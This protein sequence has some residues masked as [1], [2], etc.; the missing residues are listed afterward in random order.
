MR[1]V[2]TLAIAGVFAL[3]SGISIAKAKET[4]LP[5]IVVTATRTKTS[6]ESAPGIVEV[7]SSKEINATQPF[8]LDEALKDLPGVLTKR[9]K[10]LMDTLASIMLR[11]IPD[12]KRTLIM[13]DG[14]ILNNPYYGGV[15]LGGIFPENIKRIEVVEGPVSSLYGGY[16]MGGV[17][18]VIT[19]MPK[20]LEIKAKVG[21]GSGFSRGKAMDDLKKVFVSVGNRL[22]KFSY[23]VSY[24][25]EET[26]GYPTNPVIKSSPPA[27]TSGATYTKYIKY[28]SVSTGY[29]LGDKGDNTYWDDGVLIKLGYEFNKEHSITVDFLRLRYGYGYDT[30]H[31]YIYNSTTLQPV[32]LPSEYDFI[33]GYGGRIEDILGV[34]WKKL[35]AGKYRVKAV[36]SYLNTEKDWYVLP[37]WGA[38]FSGGAG[39]LSNTYQRRYYGDLQVSFPIFQNHLIILGG[40]VTEDYAKTTEKTL[41]NWATTEFTLGTSYESKGKTRNIGIFLQDSWFVSPIVTFYTGVRADFW[42]TYDGYV[43]QAGQTPKSYPKNSETAISPKIAVVIKPTQKTTI[44]ASIG[45]AFRCP[46]IYE[47]YRT[48]VSSWG[49]TYK[50]NPYLKPEKVWAG[51]IGLYQKLWK[52][53]NFEVTYFYNQLEDLIYRKTVGSTKE[54]INVGKAVSQGVEVGFNQ[55]L[56][57]WFK[58]FL[59]ITYTDSEIKKN[60]ADPATVGKRLTFVPLWMGNAGIDVKK[61]KFSGFVIGHYVS[62]VYADDENRDN[63][64][65]VFGSYDGYFVV[66]AGVGYSFNKNARAFLKITNLFNKKYYQYYKAPE[67]AWFA[68]VSFRF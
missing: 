2:I 62:K 48:W 10:G 44:K 14:I 61:G 36:I 64:S 3:Q 15:K 46:T 13:I 11:G 52:G 20:K 17:V 43:N 12:Q 56:K 26:N 40:S 53:A 18:N 54:Y 31:T 68:E 24:G 51:D 23:F 58:F 63:I 66:D 28:G 50:S 35:I 4:K 49:T 59:N 25:R 29:I 7:V 41:A 33:G 65:G 9:G 47:L 27:G 57:N 1:K 8:T 37:Q 55:K 19:K 67:R 38:D 45:K 34:T 6:V 22:N 21:Y 32:Y 42:E 30:P 5:E 39:K 16:A 60:D